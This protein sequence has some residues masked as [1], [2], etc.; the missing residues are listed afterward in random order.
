MACGRTS[1]PVTKRLHVSNLVEQFE[2]FSDWGPATGVDSARM[3][4]KRKSVTSAG[5]APVLTIKPAYRIALVRPDNPGAWTVIAGFSYTGAGENLAAGIDASAFT[6]GQAWIQWGISYTLSGDAPTDAQADVEVTI[7]LTSC[8]SSVGTRTQE[9]TTFNT[10]ANTFGAITGWIPAIDVAK[11]V[12]F[13]I[14]TNIQNNFRCQLCYRTAETNIQSTSAWGLLESTNYR[15][16]N[17]ETST[18]ELT[19]SLSSVMYVQFGIAYGQSS[20]GAAPATASVT[21]SVSVRR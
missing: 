2:P 14:I 6:A 20:A 10:T 18:T 13:F 5:T 19:M 1:Q 11:V 16:T 21:T 17:D 9:L 7:S 3:V 8:G 12:A 15:T 4:I